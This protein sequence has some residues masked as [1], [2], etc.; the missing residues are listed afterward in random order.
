M[1][2]SFICL[3]ICRICKERRHLLHVPFIVVSAELG[4]EIRRACMEAGAAEFVEKPAQMP[5]LVEIIRRL[6]HLK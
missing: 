3:F 2:Q 5:E 4:E 6:A 1:L